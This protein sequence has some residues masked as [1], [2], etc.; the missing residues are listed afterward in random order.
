M[1]PATLAAC[2]AAWEKANASLTFCLSSIDAI[3]KATEIEARRAALQEHTNAPLDK[4]MQVLSEPEAFL[5]H[6]SCDIHGQRCPLPHTKTND[7]SLDL[8][9]GEIRVAVA[10]STCVDHSTFGWVLN[11]D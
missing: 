4:L 2:Q 1:A 11:Q 5:S 9:D 7:A 8:A 10:G 6:A 3:D